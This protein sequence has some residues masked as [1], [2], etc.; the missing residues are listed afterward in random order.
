MFGNGKKKKLAQLATE[1]T[2]GTPITIGGVN[3]IDEH[4]VI[5]GDLEASGDIRIDGRLVGDLLCKAKVIIGLRGSVEGDV[6]CESAHI[7]GE[8]RGNMQVAQTL[9]VKETARVSGSL[10]AGVTTIGAGSTL[11]ITCT[12]NEVDAPAEEPVSPTDEKEAPAHAVA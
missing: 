1:R 9:S 3:T 12:L 7:E 10:R 4:T 5:T 11:D 2:P 6:S 8:Y